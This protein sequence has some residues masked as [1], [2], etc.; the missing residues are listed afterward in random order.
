MRQDLLYIYCTHL[1]KPCGVKL[2]NGGSSRPLGRRV[3]GSRSSSK[4]LCAQACSGVIR[5]DGVYSSSVLTRSIASGGVRGR[6]TCKYNQHT[7]RDV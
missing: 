3:E 6:N 4:K 5:L 7:I 1:F 2:N